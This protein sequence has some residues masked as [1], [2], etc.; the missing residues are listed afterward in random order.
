MDDQRDRR[1]AS[2]DDGAYRLIRPLQAELSGVAE[3]VLAGSEAEE[4]QFYWRL[5]TLHAERVAVTE[6]NELTVYRNVDGQRG[7]ASAFLA[8]DAIDQE[9]VRT[10]LTAAGLAPNPPYR[11]P[12]G[13]ATYPSIA[14]GDPVLP[15]SE[16]LKAWGTE[17]QGQ[18]AKAGCLT[19][20]LEIFA[21]RHRQRI[22]ASTGRQHAWQGDHLLLDLVVATGE[23][24]DST[25]FRVLRRHRRLGD[26]LPARVLEDAV[27]AVNDRRDAQLP[28]TG[29][30]PVV[31]PAS[32]IATLLTA[33]RV[34]TDGKYLFTGML[35]KKVG[36]ALVSCRGDAVTIA[37]NPLRDHAEDSAPTDAST[38]PAARLLLLEAGVIRGMHVDPQYAEYLGA[39]P[40]GPVGTLEWMPGTTPAA[41]LCADGPVLEV[42]AFSANMPDPM[43]GD[44]A[45]EIKMGYL[46]RGGRRIPVAQGSVTGNIFEALADCRLSRE[47][48]E[49]AGYFGPRQVRFA[50]LQVAGA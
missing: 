11:L 35:Q 24:D 1:T 33:I 49:D 37:A 29:R 13:A 19:S 15:G 23:G 25:E 43:S 5:G 9:R 7:A 48:E 6:T 28:P 22:A 47:T 30:M 18:V 50:S 36:D 21:G 34:H 46:H 26:L 40:T 44:F 2:T 42:L 16:E 3:W 31:M 32:E 39:A 14:L 8:G 17:V 4:R 12:E 27:R 41:D 20:H 10:A 38:V 45:A